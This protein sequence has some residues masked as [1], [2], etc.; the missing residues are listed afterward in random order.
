[1]TPGCT[2]W[3]VVETV[4]R[5][6]TATRSSCANTEE[7]E[8]SSTHESSTHEK[9]PDLHRLRTRV[10]SDA[11]SIFRK[12]CSRNGLFSL[13]ILSRDSFSRSHFPFWHILS[14][15]G[16]IPRPSFAFR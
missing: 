5:L 10:P 2:G 3:A 8:N 14:R 11:L 7:Q 1:M 15:K 9:R 4:G 12:Y 16:L 6:G 13:W